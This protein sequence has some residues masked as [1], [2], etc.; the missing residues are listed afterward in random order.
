MNSDLL[1]LKL[2]LFHFF[3]RWEHPDTCEWESGWDKGGG[4]WKPP[5]PFLAHEKDLLG[6]VGHQR[7]WAAC[8]REALSAQSLKTASRGHRTDAG[9]SEKQPGH[10]KGMQRVTFLP[11]PSTLGF[12]ESP[13]LWKNVVLI[14]ADGC[15]H[16][17]L[18]GE[19][20]AVVGGRRWHL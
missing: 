6:L 8:T 14:A 1:Y 10:L 11:R 7:C 19:R 13:C 15:P 5:L 3:L 12:Q 18:G 2:S 20:A 9:P 17:S 16:S 4:V